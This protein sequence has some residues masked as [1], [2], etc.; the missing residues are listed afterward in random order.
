MVDYTFNTVHI[1]PV[2][3]SS[4][5]KLYASVAMQQQFSLINNAAKARRMIVASRRK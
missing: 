5:K 4:P 1:L 3:A 2:V